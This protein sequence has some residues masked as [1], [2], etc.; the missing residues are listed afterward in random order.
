MEARRDHSYPQQQVRV[1][2][3]PLWDDETARTFARERIAAHQQAQEGQ[4]PECTAEERWERGPVFAVKKEGRKKAVKLHQDFNRAQE[5]AEQ[6]GAKHYVETRPAQQVRCE[7]YCSA[8]PFC[9]QWQAMKQPI[10]TL[11]GPPEE[12]DEPA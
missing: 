5:H 12:E 2:T 4:L 10:V 11:P 7:N 1:L 9:D 8:A 6:C 3:V